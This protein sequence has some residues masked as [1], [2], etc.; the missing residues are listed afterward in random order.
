MQIRTGTARS[1]DLDIYYEDMGDP[2]D[3]AVLLI[4]GLG[5]QLLLWRTE[6]CEKLVD[7]G[8]RVIRYDNRDVGLSTKVTGRHTG[9][10]LAPRMVRSFLGLRSQAV[11]TLEDVADDAAALL[12]H[13]KIDT[14][15]IVGAS[16]GGMIAQVFAA[17]HKV[18]TKTLAI[19]FSS[20]NQPLLP[21]PGPR[22]LLAILQK[23]KDATREAIIDNAVRYRES[24]AAPVIRQRRSASVPRRS[25]ATTGRTTPLASAAISRRSSAAGAYFATTGWSASP[26]L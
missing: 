11:Y 12:D 26:P 17:R 25:R 15:H 4:M 10:P 23:P 6:F 24:P 14:A 1:G 18:R 19:I 20:N 21:P 9:A 2:N 7:Q 5:A 16:M 3:P 8:L 22:Q 13:L